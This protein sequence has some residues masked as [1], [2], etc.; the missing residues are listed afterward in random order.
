M[1][2]QLKALAILALATAVTAG[3]AQTTASTPGTTKTVHHKKPV[4]K[5]PSVQ[6]QIEE[7]R[8][9]EQ[10]DRGQID[11]LK[12]QL[13]D[14]DAQLQSAQQAAQQAQAA[15]QAAQQAATAEQQ[16]ISA[17]TDAVSSLQSSVSDLKANNIS[18]AGTIQEEQTATRKMVENPDAIHFKGINLSP[19]G[20]FIE[21]ATVDRTRATASDIPTPFT[22]IPLEAADA[23][24][25]SEF[26]MTGRQSRVALTAEGK[27]SN[28][29]IRGYWEADWLGV[30]VTSNN[31]KSN[32]YVLSQRVLFAQAAMR[33]GWT[34]TGGQQWSMVTEYTK[35]LNSKA[36]AVP[37]NIDP[38]YN[39]GFVWTRQP[40]FHVVKNFGT[41]A[42]LGMSV[43]NDQMLAPSCAGAIA[44]GTAPSCPTNYLYGAPGTGGGLYN[45]GGQPGASS[46]SALTTYSYNVAP[47]FVAKLAFDPKFAHMEVFGVS[48]FFRD[49]I[50][51]NT[52]SVGA[53]NNTTPAGG[54]GG[55]LR[56]HLGG[57]DLGLKG[58]YG[59]GTGR[60]GTSTLP[61]VT[62]RP[63]G[64][65][66]PLHSFSGMA[67]LEGHATKRLDLYA[68]YGG[69]YVGR[70]LAAVGAGQ[71]GYGSPFANDSG[72]MTQSN[73]GT[74]T[75][76][77][78]SPATTGT[79]ASANKDTQEFTAGYWYNFY[80]GP[81]GRLRQ[82]FQYSYLQRYLWSGLGGT[83][84][85]TND[86]VIETSL[87]YYMP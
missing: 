7:L 44:T 18:I 80:A 28:A 68:Y 12:Q 38:N 59:D 61:D 21:F 29:T 71:V 55:S 60:L 22:S 83:S 17:N 25:I 66:S 78:T 74:G 8:Q 45:N 43:E 69:E 85:N 6:A 26:E 34:F 76:T 37:F 63:D 10:S 72:C 16:S 9:Q 65:L 24:N 23:G 86:N 36:E 54:I 15:A 49:R 84:I 56:V 81:H 77:G 41:M 50:Y 13:S 82:G 2:N 33:S 5:G 11:S 20:S 30:G 73:P 1:T 42:A 67:F 31:N 14:R 40:G 79:C 52:T 32:S 57:M 75:G 64:A 3:Y 70:D 62:V 87:R 48:R 35:L 46:S 4:P 58:L 47:M 53:Y 39:V 27:V 51:P 19:T